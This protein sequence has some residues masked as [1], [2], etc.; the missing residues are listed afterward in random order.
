MKR[1]A[2]GHTDDLPENVDIMTDVDGSSPDALV[3]D[4]AEYTTVSEAVVDAV[5]SVTAIDPLEMDPLYS[6]IDLDALE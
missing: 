6:L 2:P 1:I 3:F 5:A 4:C